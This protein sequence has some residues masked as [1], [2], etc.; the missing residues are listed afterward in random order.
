MKSRKLLSGPYL[1]WA[2]SFIII[3][4][5][6][7]VYYG[8]TDKEGGFTLLNLAQITTPEN[9]KALGLALLLSFISTL[10]CLVLAYP[11]AM[12]LSEK[13]VNQTSFIVLIFILPMWMNFL[14][15][16]LAWQNLLEKNGIINSIL[17]FFHLPAQTLI[18][19]PYAIVLGMVYNFLP[20]MVLPIYNVLAKIDKDVIFA[21]RDLGANG[22]QTFSKIILPLSVPGI[23]SGITMVFVPSLTTFVISD[24]LGGSKILLIGNVIEQEFKQGSN[25][26]VGSGLSLV[27]MIFIIA[28]MA[29]IAKYDKNGEG[30]AF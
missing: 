6:M 12:I 1:F 13:N 30:T 23:I 15:R 11:L 21:A 26:H 22:I 9:L 10:L 4:L 24:L 20:F 17:G 19:T 8:L 5:L 27:L 3:P 7:I 14:L 2:A 16:T 28:S 29:L 18:N 25:W